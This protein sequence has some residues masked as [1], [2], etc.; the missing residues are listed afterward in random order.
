MGED[1]E[2]ADINLVPFKN[3]KKSFLE[4]LKFDD[5]TDKRV[6]EENEWDTYLIRLVT[7]NVRQDKKV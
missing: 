7:F 6:V 4:T 3:V 1:R 5:K 2:S